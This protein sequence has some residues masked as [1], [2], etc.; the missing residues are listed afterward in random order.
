MQDRQLPVYK[1][2]VMYVLINHAKPAIID[3]FP[4]QPA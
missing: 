1:L 2:S 3:G 4:S